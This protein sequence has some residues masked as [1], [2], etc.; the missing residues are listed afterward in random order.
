MRVEASMTS[1]SWIPSEAITGPT[2]IPIDMGFGSYDEPP[3][4]QIEDLAVLHEEGRFRFANDLRVWAE[5]VD[6]RIVDGGYAGGGHICPTEL[7]LGVGRIAIAAISLPDLQA[8]PDIGDRGITF[9]QTT[10][11]RTGAPLPRRISS[12]P[13]FRVTAPAVWTTLEVDDRPGR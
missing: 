4:D 7:S 12:P 1:V 6:G 9:T 10:G 2:R 11:G 3:P 5:I 13:F 8:E